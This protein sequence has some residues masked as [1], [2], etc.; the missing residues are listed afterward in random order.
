MKK[1]RLLLWIVLVA[2]SVTGIALHIISPTNADDL[3]HPFSGLFRSLHGAISA[4]SLCMF[5]YFFSDHVQKKLAKFKYH[6]RTHLWDAYVH[7]TVWIL[8]I[9]SGLLLYYPQDVF[10]GTMVINLHWYSGVVL[11]AL[12]PLHFW[13]KSIKRYYGRKRWEHVLA[14]KAKVN[15]DESGG[16]TDGDN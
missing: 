14:E 6:W 9:I 13:R 16:K 3:P 1:S 8:L 10:D 7:L 5:G 11:A 12:F 15:G 4:V 2:L